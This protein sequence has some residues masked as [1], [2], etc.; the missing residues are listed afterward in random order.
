MS[1]Q[2]HEGGDPT[3]PKGSCV[4]DYALARLAVIRSDDKRALL[5][6]MR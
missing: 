4:K 6:K 3:L 5:R 2:H 1:S